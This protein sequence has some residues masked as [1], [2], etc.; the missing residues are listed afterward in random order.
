MSTLIEMRK[1]DGTLVGRCDSK[2]HNAQEPVCK[3]ICGG[4]NHGVGLIKAM[5]R[6]REEY[7]VPKGEDVTVVFSDLVGQMSLL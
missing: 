2:C 4:M 5:S 6:T 7:S 3:C 1:A